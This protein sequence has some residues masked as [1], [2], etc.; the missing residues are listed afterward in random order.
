MIT[1]LFCLFNQVPV[2]APQACENSQTMC[3]KTNKRLFRLMK[4]ETARE[5]A[6]P[7]SSYS[8]ITEWK[9]K[10]LAKSH[11]QPGTLDLISTGNKPATLLENKNWLQSQLLIRQGRRNRRPIAARCNRVL[12]LRFMQRCIYHDE[13]FI[14]VSSALRVVFTLDCATN[15][16]DSRIRE[17]GLVIAAVLPL[18][19]PLCVFVNT[20]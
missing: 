19:R 6:K 14:D 13:A 18:K 3:E 4:Q 12:L 16:D 10:T 2:L 15:A 17:M 9:G 5:L 11:L 8:Y 20:E 1:L 7:S